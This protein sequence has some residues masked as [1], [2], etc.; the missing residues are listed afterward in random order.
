LSITSFISSSSRR[1]ATSGTITS[2]IGAAPVFPAT[3]IAA[4]KIA[5]ACIS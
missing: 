3:S 2:G 1:V 5:R 4:S